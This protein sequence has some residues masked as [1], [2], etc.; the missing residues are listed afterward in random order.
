MQAAWV[1]GGIFVG[2]W[3]LNKS[4]GT[5]GDDERITR[6]AVRGIT[7]AGGVVGVDWRM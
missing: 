7:L 2:L 1:L 6:M 3:A 4:Q 5:A